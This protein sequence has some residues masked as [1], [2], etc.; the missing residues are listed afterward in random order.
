MQ[1]RQ[2]IQKIIEF[3]SRSFWS[4][5]VDLRKLNETIS[6]LNTDGWKLLQMVPQQQYFGG[7][8]SYHLLVEQSE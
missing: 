2:P 8:T 5:Q 6:K 4:S 3:K 1:K 7:V